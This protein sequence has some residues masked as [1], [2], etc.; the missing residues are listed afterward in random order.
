MFEWSQLRRDLSLVF[1]HGVSSTAVFSPKSRCPFPK[2]TIP[3]HN[4]PS[5]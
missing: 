3:R 4:H 5:L 2:T 1:D